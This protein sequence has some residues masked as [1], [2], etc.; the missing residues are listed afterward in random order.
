[1][2]EYKDQYDLTDIALLPSE[3]V[4]IGEVIAVNN[5][6][7]EEV[8]FIFI[9]DD[10]IFDLLAVKDGVENGKAEFKFALFLPKSI[11]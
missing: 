8:E 5:K 11:I 3:A 7:G 6:T 4:S 10:F 1:M 2:M 9:L